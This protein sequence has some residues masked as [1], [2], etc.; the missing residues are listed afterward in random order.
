VKRS[1]L[2][3]VIAFELLGKLSLQS[4][5]AGLEAMDRSLVDITP[6]EQQDSDIQRTLPAIALLPLL[7]VA[8]GVPGCPAQNSQ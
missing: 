6:R 1:N 4:P 8:V 5:K 7:V 3:V 2:R